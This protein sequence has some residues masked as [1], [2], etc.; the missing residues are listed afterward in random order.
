MVIVCVTVAPAAES[1]VSW[2]ENL[3]P[4]T[5]CLRFAIS[6]QELIYH[7]NKIP[8][9]SR[10]ANS[11]KA[12]STEPKYCSEKCKRH[13][14]VK[15]AGSLDMRVEL[16]LGSLLLDRDPTDVQTNRNELESSVPKSKRKAKK[17]DPRIIITISELEIAVFGNRQDPEKTY[18]RKKNRAKRGVP[19]PE[20][21]KS[22]DMEDAAQ[23]IGP[24]TTEVE[25]EYL[26]DDDE[27]G[28]DGMNVMQSHVRPSQSHSTVNGS[29]GGEKGRAERVEET[30]DILQKRR[31]GQKRAE[32]RELVK[33]AAR[34]AVAFGLLIEGPPEVGR[35]KFR[36]GYGNDEHPNKMRRKC[37]AL[38]NGNVVDPSFAKG[39]WSIRW[40]E[41]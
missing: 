40:R 10:R 21:W 13:R 26:T 32:D 34:R 4:L 27:F 30:P 7:A 3:V 9:G 5:N 1:L 29:I 37:E 17:G 24:D 23:P 39:D 36:Q 20:E 25:F 2:L 14:P 38:M 31:E 18:G 28:D 16:T 8:K 12:S 11:S 19:D 33:N 41:D 35:D 15:A 22:V 6:G